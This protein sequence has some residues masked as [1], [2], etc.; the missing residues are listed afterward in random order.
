MMKPN[1][2]LL[3]VQSPSEELEI[4]DFQRIKRV[5]E[6]SMGLF[7]GTAGPVLSES[8]EVFL[9]A[10]SGKTGDGVRSTFPTASAS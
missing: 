5:E 1:K 6:T 2:T 8:R 3:G 10:W 9:D 7:D 4:R